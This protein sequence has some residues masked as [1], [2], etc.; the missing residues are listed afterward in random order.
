MHCCYRARVLSDRPSNAEAGVVLEY[1]CSQRLCDNEWHCSH[2][3]Y[4]PLRPTPGSCCRLSS[5]PC[6]CG[7]A[8][9]RFDDSFYSS[10]SMDSFVLYYNDAGGTAS[11]LSAGFQFCKPLYR[12]IWYSICQGNG[13][14]R[15]T[16]YLV[17]TSDK[18]SIPILFTDVHTLSAL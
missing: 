14:I 10:R 17:C 11:M 4:S 6:S 12:S 1:C 18:P 9:P 13:V 15:S 3:Q 5:F 2:D 16:L 8:F 7:S